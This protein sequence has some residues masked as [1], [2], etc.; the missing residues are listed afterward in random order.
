MDPRGDDTSWHLQRAEFKETLLY[1]VKLYHT[2]FVLRFHDGLCRK[3]KIKNESTELTSNNTKVVGHMVSI[4]T[5]TLF[6]NAS[7]EQVGI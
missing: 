5:S 3:S 2:V 4:K 6:L 1:L 7:N